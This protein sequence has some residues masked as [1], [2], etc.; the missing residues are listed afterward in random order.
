MLKKQS[1]SM[2]EHRNLGVKE[3]ALGLQGCSLWGGAGAAPCQTQTVP[4]GSL[5]GTAQPSTQDSGVTGKSECKKGK[6]IA[7]QVRS[8]G[9]AISHPPWTT[10]GWEVSQEW[11][12]EAEPGKARRG[13]SLIFVFISQYPNLFDTS[14][15]PFCFIWW[16]HNRMWGCTF[17]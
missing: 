2:M 16:P 10:W 8:L 15:L 5:Q 9:T 11:G 3:L 7:Q 1:N 14:K 17:T 4:V 12:N 13:G 6:N